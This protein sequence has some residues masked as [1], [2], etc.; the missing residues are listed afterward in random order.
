VPARNRADGQEEDRLQTVTASAGLPR[1]RKEVVTTVREVF[2]KG[3]DFA[4]KIT[5]NAKR[6]PVS[7]DALVTRQ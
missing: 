7:G 4:A 6:L 3:N 5:Y 2:G 1:I